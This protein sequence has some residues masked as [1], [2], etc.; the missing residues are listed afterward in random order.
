MVKLDR[1]EW[2]NQFFRKIEGLFSTYKTAL[3]VTVDNVQSKQMQM[4]RGSLRGRAEILMG[5]NT[6]IRKALRDMISP[7]E[8][9]ADRKWYEGEPRPEFVELLEMIKGNIGF[10]FTDMDTKE[11][12]DI[13]VEN[14][15]QAPAKAGIIAPLEVWI[16][17]GPTGMDAQKTSFFQALNL[18][19]KIARGVISMVNRVK[20]IAAGDKVGLSEA[21]L[22]NMLN[23]SPFFYGI[24][25][26]HVYK[27]GLV[28]PAIVLDTPQSA[29]LAKFSVGVCNIASICLALNYPSKASVPH[30]IMNGFKTLL[31]IA[32]A[33]E[34]D[35]EQADKV[36]AYLA[37]P[38]AFAS[39]AP[40][41]GGGGGGGDAPVAAAPP[42]AEESSE[43]E[44]E[45][46]LFD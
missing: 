19:T 32:V 18:P 39:A 10:C 31:A 22:L 27:D 11:C 41:G 7:A 2:K 34:I 15:V 45:G 35:F 20:L 44:M 5:K 14:Q 13:M 1:T 3:I 37:D 17:E 23:I 46:G 40:S 43:D 38:S 28:F 8:Q 30:S 16:E 12:R 36:K 21:K 24:K 42:P 6:L 4:V 9:K 25:V 29:V 33:T 26:F